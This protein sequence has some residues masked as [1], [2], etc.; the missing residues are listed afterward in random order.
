[1][2]G[3]LVLDGV[4]W[5]QQ[6]GYEPCDTDQREDEAVNQ[7]E[8]TNVHTH[9]LR[10]KWHCTVQSAC[11]PLSGARSN[12]GARR[13]TYSVSVLARLLVAPASATRRSNTMFAKLSAELI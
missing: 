10:K 4:G 11:H 12:P 6:R 1:M 7:G 2:D 9:L 13:R 3:K 8:S 5:G